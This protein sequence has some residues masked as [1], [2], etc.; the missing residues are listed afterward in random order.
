MPGLLN[1]LADPESQ[2]A[3]KNGLLD[4]ANRGMVAGTLGGPVDLATTVA[5]LGIA[6]AGYL[7]HKAGLLDRPP[8]LINPL[9][10]PGSSEWIGQKMQN[11]GMVSPNRNALAE[12]GMGLLSPVA[13][14][15]AQKFGGLLYNVEQNA[16]ANASKPSAMRMQGQRGIFAGEWAKTADKNAL[17]A[18]KKME[19]DKA[20][21]RAIWSETGWFKA[22]DGKWRF[23]IDDSASLVN[24]SALPEKEF[25]ASGQSLGTHADFKVDDALEHSKLF[26]AYP[27]VR[28]IQMSFTGED[29]GRGANY[30][31]GVDWISL[32]NSYKEPTLSSAGQSTVSA[33]S[34]ELNALRTSKRQTRYDA[35]T[36]AILDRNGANFLDPRLV[37]VVEKFGTPLETKRLG[38]L[39]K[40][41]DAKESMTTGVRLADSGRSTLLHELQH[42]I[43]KREG[44]AAGGSPEDFPDAETLSTAHILAI[45]MRRGEL[46]SEAAAWVRD[47]TNKNPTP[48]AIDLAMGGAD[49]LRKLGDSPSSA[50][51]RLAGEAEAR[52][53]QSRMN[54]SEAQ[55][56]ASFP[57][58]SYDVPLDSLIIKY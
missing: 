57:L 29:G 54:M 9:S 16:L 31:P 1:F 44:F 48:Q 8:E 11:A 3:M 5:N 46:P 7:G 24:S 17:S 21:P 26:D 50:Y 49:L 38:L 13:F 23:E 28:K 39:D 18:A 30:K 35:L 20:D 22:P 42:A 33:L 15:G 34:A 6:G 51:R 40:I 45:R 43:Q 2:R 41:D 52:A 36:D 53:V 47:N 56:R 10:V 12:A 32:G 19:A 55:R 25:F 14:K 27:D 58:D 4:A 37:K